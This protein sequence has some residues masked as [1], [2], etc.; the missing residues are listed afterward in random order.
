MVNPF[1]SI[2]LS[3]ELMGFWDH[4]VIIGDLR[5]EFMVVRWFK[6]GCAGVDNPLLDSFCLC[7]PSF[8]NSRPRESEPA[9]RE[10]PSYSG[11]DLLVQPFGVS[12]GNALPRVLPLKPEGYT[13]QPPPYYPSRNNSL[14]V[15]PLRLVRASRKRRPPKQPPPP[16]YYETCSRTLYQS[17]TTLSFEAPDPPPPYSEKV[18]T[19]GIM[20]KV[21]TTTLPSGPGAPGSSPG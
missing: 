3:Y 11:P 20:P 16:S 17:V 1:H 12:A 7:L 15:K 14:E 10:L 5:V 19:Q 13:V 8:P 2:V 4:S 9:L 18:A 6:I 21:G